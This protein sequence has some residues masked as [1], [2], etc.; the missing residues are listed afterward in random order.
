VRKLSRSVSAR[1]FE[2]PE[3]GCSLTEVTDPIKFGEEVVKI[4]VRTGYSKGHIMEDAKV[5]WNPKSTDP[6]MIENAMAETIPYSNAHAI[7]GEA[8]QDG[9]FAPFALPGDSGVDSAACRTGCSRSCYYCGGC[10]DYIRD[11]VGG[12]THFFHF[13]L[14]SALRHQ[15]NSE[16]GTCS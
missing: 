2:F 5:R 1:E 11:F 6:L 7:L 14:S 3:Q 4:G 16:A 9:T 8:L 13:A 10:W 12:N 15:G